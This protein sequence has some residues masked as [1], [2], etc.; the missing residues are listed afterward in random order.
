MLTEIKTA[1]DMLKLPFYVTAALNFSEQ[2]GTRSGREIAKASKKQMIQTAVVRAIK[3]QAISFD[4]GRELL[5]ARGAYG[6]KGKKA[7]EACK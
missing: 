1:A 6:P 4:L 5:I 3:E 7:L 2:R